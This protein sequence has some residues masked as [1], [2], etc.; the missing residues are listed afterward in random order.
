MT[1]KEYH[2]IRYKRRVLPAQLKR[3]ERRLEQLRKDAKELGMEH[4]LKPR[5]AKT[6][7][8]ILANHS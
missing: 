8:N 3:A 2:Y 5:E 1:E 4:L 7:V 6:H